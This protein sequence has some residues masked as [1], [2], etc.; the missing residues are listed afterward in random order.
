MTG[1]RA[2]D[3]QVAA[4]LDFGRLGYLLIVFA[5]GSA[6]LL[7]EAHGRQSFQVLQM[8]SE[9]CSSLNALGLFAGLF[10]FGHNLIK[11]GRCEAAQVDCHEDFAFE[12]IVELNAI[13]QIFQ[14]SLAELLIDCLEPGIRGFATTH[15]P[16]N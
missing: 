1:D 14:P 12:L 8:L 4:I 7:I 6:G 2:I 5:T 13:N 10:Y 16:F 11:L 15:F 9:L 3:F